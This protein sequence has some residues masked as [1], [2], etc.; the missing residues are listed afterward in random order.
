ML[1]LYV[2]FKLVASAK[3]RFLPHVDELIQAMAREPSFVTAVLN[4]DPNS[5]DELV[6]FEVWNG[7]RDEWVAQQPQK[8]YRSVY[9]DATKELVADKEVRFLSPI[10]IRN[11]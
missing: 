2:R 8:P 1:A 4:E 5:E 3:S 6:L 7:S 9:E 10:A 11:G